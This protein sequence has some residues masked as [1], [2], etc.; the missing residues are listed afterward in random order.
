MSGTAILV[1]APGKVILCGEHAVVHG[2][3]RRVCALRDPFLPLLTNQGDP[4]AASVTQT[5]I[6]VS[7]GL[8]TFVRL[9][10]AR[11]LDT[12]RL[13]LPDI[14]IH[15]TWPVAELQ[16]LRQVLF[17]AGKTAVADH[18]H[19]HLEVSLMCSAPPSYAQDVAAATPAEQ[20]VTA[21]LRA[22]LEAAVK[23]DGS[24]KSL[25]TVAFVYLFLAIGL[26]SVMGYAT[27]TSESTRSSLK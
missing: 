10:S 11:A 1:S 4:A 2:R 20:P 14:G 27:T 3:V 6:A 26:D 21:E 16:A 24:S 7:L 19:G 9:T 18:R 15:A 12:V 5:A 23:A 8:R 17:G 13:D 22:A 25:A